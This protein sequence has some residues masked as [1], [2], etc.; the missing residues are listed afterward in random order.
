MRASGPRI[1]V[2]IW[3]GRATLATGKDE[4]VTFSK[5]ELNLKDHMGLRAE[6]FGPLVFLLGIVNLTVDKG[7]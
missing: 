3:V 5:S 7:G 2:D 1:P 4:Q 6:P